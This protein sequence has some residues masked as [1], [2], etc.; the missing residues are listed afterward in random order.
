MV[1]KPGREPG[2]EPGDGSYRFVVKARALNKEVIQDH[3][4]LP[5]IKNI[6]DRL[7]ET[8]I[9]SSLDFVSS[10]TQVGLVKTSR[11]FTAFSY[12]GKHYMWTRMLQGQT[13]SSAECSRCVDLLWQRVPFKDLIYYIDDFLVSSATYEEHI[14]R[15]KF[16]FDR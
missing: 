12:N 4:E 5:K 3:Y 16:I 15:L 13:S 1:R 2:S 6:L 10:F 9:F 8:E 11:S 14:E 7:K